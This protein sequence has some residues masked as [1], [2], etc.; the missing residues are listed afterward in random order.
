[1]TGPR[2]RVVPLGD[3][4][5][6]ASR[7]GRGAR[8]RC[9]ADSPG[10]WTVTQ[11]SADLAWRSRR[12]GGARPGDLV[13]AFGT[14]CLVRCPRITAARASPPGAAPRDARHA[15]RVRGLRIR[16]ARTGVT[17]DAHGRP[18]VSATGRLG[19]QGAVRRC[20]DLLASSRRSP[21][22][23]A[24]RARGRQR[25]ASHTTVFLDE[26]APGLTPHDVATPCS[27]RTGQAWPWTTRG[28]SASAR[29]RGLQDPQ[30]PRRPRCRRRPRTCTSSCGTSLRRRPRV[31]ATGTTRSR[32]RAR[33]DVVI[34]DVMGH[35]TP[36]A[37]AMSQLRT[38]C[39]A[40][41]TQ[42]ARRPRR[43]SRRARALGIDGWRQLSSSGSRSRAAPGRGRKD[44]AL[45]EPRP[46]A[47][48]IPRAGTVKSLRPRGGRV[49]L[50]PGDARTDQCGRLPGW[51]PSS[52]RAR[53]HRGEHL[54]YGHP[55]RRSPV[56]AS[57]RC[58]P[59]GWTRTVACTSCCGERHEC[60]RPT[61]PVVAVN[62]ELPAVS[63]SPVSC[64]APVGGLGRGGCT[65]ALLEDSDRTASRA[66]AT[67][68]C[69]RLGE[70]ASRRCCDYA[71]TPHYGSMDDECTG[72]ARRVVVTNGHVAAAKRAWLGARDG[73]AH[74]VTVEPASTCPAT[75]IGSGAAGRR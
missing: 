30:A 21:L 51:H 8:P 61:G 6:F 46:S 40:S 68:T 33:P 75:H 70:G 60:G 4:A 23:S 58:R 27:W 63:W 36:A 47:P 24:V 22:R 29:D 59:A 69:P 20:R 37:A 73:G 48:V 31:G 64:R 52:R 55:P 45:G 25:S 26:V 62:L 44:A 65:I 19:P 2:R 49:G 9:G 28:S 66:F 71:S 53:R 32:S 18:V 16:R 14:W 50:A 57:R 43:C 12:V 41:R 3:T 1:M 72:A 38:R 74:Q 67:I 17:H 15:K 35:D 7:A 5:A 39:A 13:P 42:A 10:G 11:V 56:E 54:R 34:G